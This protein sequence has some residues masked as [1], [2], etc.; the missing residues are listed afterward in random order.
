MQDIRSWG[1]AA[2]DGVG[3]R[4]KNVQRERERDPKEG[5]G[6]VGLQKARRSLKGKTSSDTRT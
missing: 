4:Q 5:P 1:A 3:G 2:E 6:R